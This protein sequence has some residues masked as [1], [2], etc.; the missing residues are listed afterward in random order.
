MSSTTA[1]TPI[2]LPDHE[3]PSPV[4]PPV[5]PSRQASYW[6]QAHRATRLNR[7]SAQPRS[8]YMAGIDSDIERRWRNCVAE[9][10]RLRNI[11]DNWDGFDAP[12]PDPNVVDLAIVFLNVC[13]TRDFTNPPFRAAVSPDGT[14]C[15]EWQGGGYYLEAEVVSP[16]RVEW[17]E[18]LNGNKPIHWVE[19]PLDTE[20]RSDDCFG[21]NT[22][23]AGAAES[24]AQR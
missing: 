19:N 11:G 2:W 3:Q 6:E 18:V 14:V 12:A 23:V 7:D 16:S 22:I 13:R 17:M 21:T 9:L 24:V 5:Q 4:E 10:R 8:T 1:L 20:V 15:I